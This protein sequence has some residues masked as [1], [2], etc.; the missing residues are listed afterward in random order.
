MKGRALVNAPTWGALDGPV[1]SGDCI[2][3]MAAIPDCSVDAVV[4]DPP[5]GLEF[6]GKDWDGADGFHRSLNTADVGRDDPFGR[7]SRTS[8]EYRAGKLFQD[9][10]ERW[11]SETLRI[12]KPGGHLLAF[13]GTRTYHRLACAIED[14]G[15]E[16]RD[17]I[18][19]LYG[20]LT[21]DVEVL[22]ENGW[23]LG[24]EVGV[25][26]RVACWDADTEA[27]ELGDVRETIRAPYSG[28][29]RRLVNHD[30]DQLLTPNHRVYQR[31]QERQQRDGVRESWWTEGWQVTEAANVSRWKPT[32]L[33]LAGYADGP[34][35]GGEDYA[36]LLGWVWTE[37]GFD[38]TGTG[39]RIYQSSVN[40]DR[41]A[42]ID[43]LLGRI[44]PQHRRYDRT[45][46]YRGREYVETMWFFSGELAERVRADLPGKRPTYALL[47]R[48][49]LAERRALWDAAMK[50]DGSGDDFYSK[51]P[52]DLEW[53]QSLLATMGQRGKIAMRRDRE[54]GSVCVTPRP[55]T[56]L[57]RR[58]LAEPDEEW[59][60]EVWC[61]RVPTGAFVCR[62]N[63]RI[64]IT[65]NSGFPK[66]LD[67]SKAIDKAAGAEREVVGRGE[68]W[69]ASKIV[70]GK[71]GY[72]DYA[73]E[74]DET[75]PATPEA[76]AWEG[77][78]TALKPSHE[79]IV[80]ARKP[81][82]GTLEAA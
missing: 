12:L 66:S 76:K 56:E 54:G 64:F 81:L 46:E 1:L 82:A 48:L 36:A 4:C 3:V 62:R 10:T 28:P 68:N 25:G 37:G 20:C 21:P 50:G 32:R 65:G 33:P 8:P 7:A 61:L 57:Q 22:T 41:V 19:W 60:G 59:V 45:R 49:S 52:A 30:T 27:I 78:G 44:A 80:V 63:G 23:R 9:W 38:A 67:V 39:V 26:E 74:W 13:G 14:A 40:A 31:T 34:G 47:W 29:M 72:G 42:E 5:Y 2:D 79:P 77:F 53:A 71:T 18:M 35:I 75:A 16:I 58:H 70:D 17:S 55:T 69:G 24:I 43:T 6:M 51:H 11:A 15:F 73:G